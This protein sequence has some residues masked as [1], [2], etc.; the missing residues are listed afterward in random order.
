MY[1]P[2]THVPQQRHLLLVGVVLEAADG[3]VVRYTPVAAMASW[4]PKSAACR[5]TW[6]TMSRSG[7]RPA[8][9]QSSRAGRVFSPRSVCG[10]S[11]A[12]AAHR[13]PGGRPQQNGVPALGAFGRNGGLYQARPKGRRL[14]RAAVRS[15][16]QGSMPSSSS[17]Q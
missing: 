17:P 7:V 2:L 14:R 12:P 15:G 5:S 16:R 10:A 13:R 6:Q 8:R 9:K 1:P 3:V 11:A 4:G